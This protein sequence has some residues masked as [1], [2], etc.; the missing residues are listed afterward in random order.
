MD[1]IDSAGEGYSSM[2]I[3]EPKKEAVEEAEV[4]EEAAHEEAA[5]EEEKK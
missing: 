5:E 2:E 1:K 4:I 3:P